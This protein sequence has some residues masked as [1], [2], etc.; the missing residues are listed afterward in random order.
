METCEKTQHWGGAEQSAYQEYAYLNA[1]VR[2]PIRE[3]IV[4]HFRVVQE[5]S[6]ESKGSLLVRLC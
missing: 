3:E 5:P 2:P 1:S 6:E 4:S